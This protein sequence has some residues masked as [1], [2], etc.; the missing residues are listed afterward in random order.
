MEHSG[1]RHGC[2]MAA[3]TLRHGLEPFGGHCTQAFSWATESRPSGRETPQF[4][5]AGQDQFFRAT[6]FHSN[7][8]PVKGLVPYYFWIAVLEPYPH[9]C[10]RSEGRP[11]APITGNGAASTCFVRRFA[12]ASRLTNNR[13]VRFDA[14]R[15]LSPKVSGFASQ[16]VG[17]FG[18]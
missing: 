11:A 14:Y 18:P 13:F 4:N 8:T 7:P 12:A 15:L 5:A 10:V 16:K 9:T 6:R 2:E 17:F 1:Y 3:P